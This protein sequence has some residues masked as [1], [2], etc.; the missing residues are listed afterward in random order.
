MI[1]SLDETKQYLRV[2]NTEED[3]L[4]TSLIQAAETYLENATGNLFD[5]TN[6]LAKLFCLVLV[7]DWYE[8]REHTGKAGDNV[9]MIVESMIAQLQHAY[10]IIQT[11]ALPDATIG[12]YYEASLSAIGGLTPYTWAIAS[13]ELPEGL[14][15]DERT[16]IVS[17]TPTISGQVTVTIQLIDSSP[18]P[19]VVSR[20]LTI[21]VVEL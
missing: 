18:T 17:G 11:T 1:L 16:G 5:S 12:V 6:Q 8:N 14:I 10:P 4:I 19:K 3:V 9:R 20:P 7:A 21:V 2:D 15:L 13:G